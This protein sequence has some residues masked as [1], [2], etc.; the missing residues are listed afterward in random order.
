MRAGWLEVGQP[1]AF[2]RMETAKVHAALEAAKGKIPEAATLLG[3]TSIALKKIINADD[4]LKQRWA[5]AGSKGT[6]SPKEASTIH[7]PAAPAISVGGKELEFNDA[8]EIAVAME[9]EDAAVREGLLKMGVRGAGLEM[10]MAMQQVQRKHFARC[11]EIVGGGITKQAI[12]ILGEVEL[13]SKRLSEVGV[14]LDEQIMLREDRRGLLDI[15]GRYKDK[16]DKSA[17]IQAMVKKV[18]ADIKKGGKG[19]SAGKP[20]FGTLLVKGEKVEIHEHTPAQ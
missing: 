9:D 20:G 11:I 13:I 12:D 19:G 3:T 17:L 7:R 8:K 15:L 10:V 14:P 16:V 18:E 5:I 4:G 2:N 6:G 1:A